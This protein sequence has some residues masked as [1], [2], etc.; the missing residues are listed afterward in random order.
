MNWVDEIEYY[1][2]LGSRAYDQISAA[3]LWTEY[4]EGL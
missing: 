3:F 1:G 4:A 2:E